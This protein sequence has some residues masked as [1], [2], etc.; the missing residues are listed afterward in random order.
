MHK[1]GGLHPEFR[2]DVQRLL[3]AGKQLNL[4]PIV[5]SGHRTN[6]QQKGLFLSANSYLPV[7]PPGQSLHGLGL[8]VDIVSDDNATLGRIWG[9]MG[10]HWGGTRDWVAFAV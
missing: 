8:E 7:A 3:R 2:E 9:Q 5:T 4:T 1:L 6:Q 10:H